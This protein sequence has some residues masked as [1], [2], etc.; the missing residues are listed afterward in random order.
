[1]HLSKL[2]GK[3]SLGLSALLAQR[4]SETKP[5][6]LLQSPGDEPS[7]DSKFSHFDGLR[8]ATEQAF[9]PPAADGLEMH[10]EFLTLPDVSILQMPETRPLSQSAVASSTGIAN[11][12]LHAC[13]ISGIAAWK[14]CDDL[15]D[16]APSHS[17]QERVSEVSTGSANK[18]QI[19]S[20]LHTDVNIFQQNSRDISSIFDEK[21]KKII[22][23][24]NAATASLKLQLQSMQQERDDVVLE[25]S[26]LSA[27]IEEQKHEQQTQL[28]SFSLKLLQ[29]EAEMRKHK[30]EILEMREQIDL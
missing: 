27:T 11:W 13:Q 25:V 22:V 10:Q 9:A 21:Q 18:V 28:L 29:D 30:D 8:Y 17:R 1:M 14:A 7:S 24:L 15:L 4:N 16:F 5:V 2:Q 6:G 20:T 26:M 23:D 3:R 19:L 12:K